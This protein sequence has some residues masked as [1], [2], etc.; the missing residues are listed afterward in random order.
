MAMFIHAS[1]E[2]GKNSMPGV[3]LSYALWH[4]YFNGDR[5]VIG[6]IVQMN[7]HPFTIIGGRAR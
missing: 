5:A 4:S 7:K 3:V 1:E 6:R 2:H